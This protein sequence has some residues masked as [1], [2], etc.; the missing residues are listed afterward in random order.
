MLALFDDLE[1]QAAAHYAADRTAELADRS[2][3]EYRAVTLAARLMASVDTDVAL[4]VLGIGPVRGRLERVAESWC[5]LRGAGQDWIVALNAVTAAEGVSPRAVPEVA[6]PR[7]ARLGVGSPLRSL[8]GAGSP[9][10]LVGRDGGRRDGTLGRVGADF[11]ELRTGEPARVVLVAFA[12][13]AAV[14]SREAD[15][16]P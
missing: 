15:R 14:A 3:T 2:R 13:L 12:G 4:Q 9:V 1:Q 5:L 10:V 16:E 8:A 7:V 6:W 11:V